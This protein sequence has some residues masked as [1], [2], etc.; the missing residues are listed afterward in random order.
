MD[1]VLLWYSIGKVKHLYPL[2]RCIGDDIYIGKRVRIH[3]TLIKTTPGIPSPGN[4]FID[5]VIQIRA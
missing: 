2:M 1:E 4:I 3:I 5:I